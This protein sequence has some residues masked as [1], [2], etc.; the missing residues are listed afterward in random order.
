M[1]FVFHFYHKK[2]VNFHNIVFGQIFDPF[3]EEMQVL[4]V[5]FVHIKR[6][7]FISALSSREILFKIISKNALKKTSK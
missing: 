1:T 3:F 5:W 7:T 4:Y 6:E 2:F